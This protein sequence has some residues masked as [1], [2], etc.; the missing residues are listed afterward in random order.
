[1]VN[2]K[3]VCIYKMPFKNTGSKEGYKNVDENNKFGANKRS[4]SAKL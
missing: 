2:V 1:M 3:N 4:Y